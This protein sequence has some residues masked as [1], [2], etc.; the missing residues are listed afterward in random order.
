M[1]EPEGQTWRSFIGQIILDS[2][3]KQ[4]LIDELHINPVTPKRWADNQATPRMQTVIKLVKAL[5]KHRTRLLEL[6]SKEFGDITI[7]EEEEIAET[8]SYEIPGNFYAEVIRLYTTALKHQRFW[9]ICKKVLPDALERLDL[10]HQGMSIMVARCMK[11]NPGE[12]VRSLRE[13]IGRGT[14]PWEPDLDKEGVLLG[15]DALAGY[16][17]VNARPWTIQSQDEWQKRFPAQWTPFEKSATVHPII[18]EGCIAGCLIFMCTQEHYWTIM[19]IKLAQ[20]YTDLLTLAFDDADFYSHEQIELG[21]MPSPTVQRT[22]LKGILERIYQ[23]MRH[24]KLTYLEAES[25]V[26]KQM[27][28]ELLE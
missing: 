10:D 9:D 24:D 20:Q 5:P 18:R 13:I 14:N 12:K 17:V 25:K 21:V 7:P 6:L 4:R 2:Q 1:K 16:A 11:P 22:I 23:V 3:E 8:A 27:E 28:K 15:L 19:R 26:W